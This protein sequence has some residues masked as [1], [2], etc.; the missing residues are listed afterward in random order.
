MSNRHFISFDS[1]KKVLIGE[2]LFLSI[3]L[4]GT[5]PDVKISELRKGESHER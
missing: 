2:A 5:K 3:L 1:I 4:P